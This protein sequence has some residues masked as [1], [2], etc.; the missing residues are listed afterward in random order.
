M[1]SAPTDDYIR[2]VGLQ[3]RGKE[4]RLNLEGSWGSQSGL[5]LT[6][7]PKGGRFDSL[8]RVFTKFYY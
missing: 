7:F 1:S 6:E 8:F 3:R 5:E 4:I 2:V